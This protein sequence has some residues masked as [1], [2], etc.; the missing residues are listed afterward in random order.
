[1]SQSF[2]K[3]SF[4][5]QR[6][7]DNWICTYKRIKLDPFLTPYIKINSKWS[8]DVNI[9]AKII[10]ILEENMGVSLHDLRLG[11]GLKY[12]TK[13]TR[14]KQTKKDD[15]YSIEINNFYASEIIE[16]KDNPQNWQKKKK[17][18]SIHLSDKDLVSRVCRELIQFSSVQ[19]L[20]C[21]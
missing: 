13:G 12:D 9:R 7:W 19:S 15:F 5:H 18:F 1:M 8:K 21:V 16:G 3:N 6:C 20:S 11:N 17:F 4:F 10:K 2:N 14:N